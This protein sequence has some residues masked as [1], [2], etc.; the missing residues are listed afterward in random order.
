[1]V[2]FKMILLTTITTSAGIFAVSKSLECLSQGRLQHLGVHPDHRVR[3][4]QRLRALPVPRHQR[5]GQR[6]LQHQ[7][8]WQGQAGATRQPGGH[9]D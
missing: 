6:H 8:H 3:V 1:M 7:S 9:D 2:H 5:A 4:Q